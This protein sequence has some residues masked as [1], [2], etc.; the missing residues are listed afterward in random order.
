M[1]K[2]ILTIAI[3]TASAFANAEYMMHIPLEKAGG[4]AL[5]N[6]SIN[7]VKN[8]VNPTN[9]APEPV[10]PETPALTPEQACFA[11]ENEA[12]SLV[13]AHAVNATFTTLR[14]RPNTN[15]GPQCEVQISA[16]RSMFCGPDEVAKQI[17][18]GNNFLA[19]NFTLYVALYGT[20]L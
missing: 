6:G 7:I 20:C 13:A 2:T 3:L 17:A 12:R 8:E 19:N 16:P 10:E 9:P 14:L 1:K 5:P 11:R 18:L 4:G 15:N